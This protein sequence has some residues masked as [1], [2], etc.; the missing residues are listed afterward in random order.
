[1][2][3]NTLLEASA[4]AITAFGGLYTGYR[5]I[6]TGIQFKKDRERQEL[7]NRANEEMLKVKKELE[8]KIQKLE[9]EVK[10][11]KENIYRDLGHLKEIY[12]AE[13][14]VLSGKIDEIKLNLQDQHSAIMTLLTRLI[15]SK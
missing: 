6:C 10:S 5:R 11:Q 14:K 13:M 8:E 3:I 15:D 2:D 7:L 9:E 12:G 4:G 1:M